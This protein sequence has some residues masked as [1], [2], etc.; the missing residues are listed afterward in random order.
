MKERRPKLYRLIAD[1]THEKNNC[2]ITIVG[3]KDTVIIENKNVDHGEISPCNKEEADTSMF[4]HIKDEVWE[5]KKIKVFTVDSDVVIIALFVFFSLQQ[6]KNENWIPIHTYAEILG[7]R[8]M[9]L[10]YLSFIHVRY[11]FPICRKR[12]KKCMEN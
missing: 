10:L 1:L 7:K 2:E 4:L 5:Y 6:Q 11:N 8:C 9:A 12:Q 3:T